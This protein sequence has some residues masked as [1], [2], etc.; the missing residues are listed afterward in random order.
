MSKL[1]VVRIRDAIDASQVTIV[2]TDRRI[3]DSQCR[4]AARAKETQQV[5][6]AAI[7]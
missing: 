2:S 4:L 5:K 6:S 3:H 7:E 1:H